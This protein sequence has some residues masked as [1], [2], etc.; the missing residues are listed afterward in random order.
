[1]RPLLRPF[2]VWKHILCSSVGIFCFLVDI[3]L[4]GVKALLLVLATCGISKSNSFWN[5]SFVG[6]LSL[7][8]SG[9]KDV[10]RKQ[11]Q[12]IS[13][14]LWWWEPFPVSFKRFKSVATIWKWWF[15][16]LLK[17]NFKI[18]TLL[19]F[20]FEMLWYWSRSFYDLVCIL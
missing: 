18:I 12:F 19:S 2:L 7:Y 13:P 20:S 3:L 15:S 11:Q 4:D 8:K 10:G 17:Q 5:Y 16:I 14:C 9:V 1:M 6:G